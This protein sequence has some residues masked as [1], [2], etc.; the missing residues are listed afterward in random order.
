[1]STKLIRIPASVPLSVISE[2]VNSHQKALKE[3]YFLNKHIKQC[4]S[5][6]DN[7]IN[8]NLTYAKNT[9]KSLTDRELT[10]YMHEELGYDYAN[11]RLIARYLK[12]SEN[13]TFQMAADAQHEEATKK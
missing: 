5:I 6:I 12:G 11:A 9:A 2:A 1:M 13:I 3:N 8:G 10:E 4:Q 7:F